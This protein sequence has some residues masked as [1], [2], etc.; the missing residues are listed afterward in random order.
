MNIFAVLLVILFAGAGVVSLFQKN[1]DQA[2]YGFLG[3]A[4]NYVVYFKPFH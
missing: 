2:A 1:F 4:I 3:A